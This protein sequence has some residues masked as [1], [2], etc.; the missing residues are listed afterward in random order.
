VVRSLLVNAGAFNA[1]D[2]LFRA[3]VADVPPEGS[4]AAAELAT[5]VSAA[6][7]QCRPDPPAL[8]RALAHGVAQKEEAA[9]RRRH[10][11]ELRKKRGY[12]CGRAR[13]LSP[14]R[15]AATWTPNR[16]GWVAP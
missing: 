10:N 14:D 8:T 1:L 6:P 11:E 15:R 2:A 13:H 7:C 3:T 9:R 12:R 4:A 16:P 5:Q